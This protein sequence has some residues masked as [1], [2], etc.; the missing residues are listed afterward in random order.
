[1][2]SNACHTGF[3][4]LSN[5]RQK[6]FL[7]THAYEQRK[8]DETSVLRTDE[9]L[10]MTGRMMRDTSIGDSSSAVAVL[11]SLLRKRKSNLNTYHDNL[12]PF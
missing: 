10:G 2:G 4:K 9:P 6:Q 8:D 3:Q 1:M 7:T 5:L 12:V 11:M